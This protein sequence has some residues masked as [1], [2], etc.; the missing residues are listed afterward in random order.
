M[1]KFVKAN[2]THPAWSILFS[3]IA[4]K[5]ALATGAAIAHR[6]GRSIRSPVP[7]LEG[8][9]AQKAAPRAWGGSCRTARAQDGD[10]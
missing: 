7:S 2:A 5:Q 8:A 4:G 6:E 3:E 1:G 9:I 10:S